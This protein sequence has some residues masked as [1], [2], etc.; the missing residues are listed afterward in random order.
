V[1]LLTGNLLI[2]VVVHSALDLRML[3][4]LRPPA[5]AKAA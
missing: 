5:A 4:V 2:P 1:F 3:L